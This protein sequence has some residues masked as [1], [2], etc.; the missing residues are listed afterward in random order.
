MALSDIDRKLL[1]RCFAN[2]SQAWEDFADRFLGLVVHVVTHTAETRSLKLTL[3]DREDLVSEVFLQILDNDYAVLRRFEGRSSLATYL[4]VIARRVV[5]RKLLSSMSGLSS[6]THAAYS[7]SSA[8]PAG[9]V[10][11]DSA[12]P[13][14]QRIEDADYVHQLIRLLDDHESQVVQ[15]YHLEGKTYHEIS[16]ITG[17][18]ENSIGPA[19][20]RA[21][22][23]MRRSVPPPATGSGFT[24]SADQPTS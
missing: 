12:P 2:E 7:N 21:R 8:Q 13:M 19:L 18:S 3:P 6:G 20:S 15:M 14:E 4:A 10:L 16:R 24:A 17:L 1:E 9:D 5:V 11:V 22:E 23:K